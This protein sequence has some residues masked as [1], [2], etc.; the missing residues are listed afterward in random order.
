MGAY[1]DEKESLRRKVERLEREK[2]ESDE[3]L[4][5]EL[6]VLRRENRRLKANR[7]GPD[8]LTGGER[9]VK[10]RQDRIARTFGIASVTIGSLIVVTGLFI[11]SQAGISIRA[12]VCFFG[13]GGLLVAWGAQRVIV[14]R[15]HD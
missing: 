10:Q 4:E 3:A 6:D 15:D 7:L 1:R 14:G 11:T 8:G 13:I 12:M 5:L 9:A 2:A